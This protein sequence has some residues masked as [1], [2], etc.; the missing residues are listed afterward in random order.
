MASA[1]VI[2]WILGNGLYAYIY[3]PEGKSQVG[4]KI[5]EDSPLW[6]EIVDTVGGW[7]DSSIYES[8][9]AELSSIV[10]SKGYSLPPYDPKYYDGGV[11]LNGYKLALLSGVGGAGGGSGSGTGPSGGVADGIDTSA[12]DKFMEEMDKELNKAKEDLEKKAEEI[13]NYVEK[14]F[15]ETYFDAKDE[16]A[17]TKEELD[18]MREDLEE[19]Y[20]GAMDALDAAREALADGKIDSDEPIQLFKNRA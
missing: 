19:K 13:K 20:N 12:Y 10:Q 3:M 15:N 17:H 18:K 11:Q 4:N 1:K 16:I 6:Q 2:S 14:E 7:T 9:Y 8:A 5:V